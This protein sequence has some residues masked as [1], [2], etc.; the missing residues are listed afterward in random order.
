MKAIITT[1]A[2][3][4]CAIALAQPSSLDTTFGNNDSVFTPLSTTKLVSTAGM[5]TFYF[6]KN[7]AKILGGS[8]SAFNLTNKY[9][10]L[11]KKRTTIW[12]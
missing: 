1:I 2:M 7:A 5:S 12:Q 10:S 6:F 9:K 11:T 4:L 3:A 8:H